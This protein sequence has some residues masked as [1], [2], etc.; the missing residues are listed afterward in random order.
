MC[1]RSIS[2]GAPSIGAKRLLALK[3]PKQGSGARQD[4]IRV[5]AQKV[6][7]LTRRFSTFSYRPER[8]RVHLL[9]VKPGLVGETNQPKTARSVAEAAKVHADGKLVDSW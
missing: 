1:T 5:P 7:S 6:Q 8:C 4:E 2:E 9:E 3:S